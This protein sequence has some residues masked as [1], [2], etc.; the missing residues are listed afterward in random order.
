MKN[1]EN[2]EK[3]ELAKEELIEAVHQQINSQD[4]V[5]VREI[6]ERLLKIGYPANE[7]IEKIAEKL[8]QEVL[9]MVENEE[10]FKEDRYKIYLE[11]IFLENE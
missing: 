4:T 6:Y 8:E 7:A 10:D 9:E 1:N 2:N 11:S 5:Y 3:D